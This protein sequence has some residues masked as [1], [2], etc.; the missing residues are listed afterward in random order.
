MTER[1][2]IVSE[3][4]DKFYELTDVI[5]EMMAVE[6]VTEEWAINYFMKG[7]E[8]TRCMKFPKGT[9]MRTISAWITQ[10]MDLGNMFKTDIQ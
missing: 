4:R 3:K 8:G 9:A 2:F 10:D 1:I 5:P 7:L 6:N